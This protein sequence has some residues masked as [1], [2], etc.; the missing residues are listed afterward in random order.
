MK[1]DVI[2]PALNE[3]KTIGNIIKVFKGHPSIGMVLV[4]VDDETTDITAKIANY[5][6][7]N[8]R[9][10]AGLHGKGQLIQ[11]GLESVVG[12]H[13]ILCDGDY[14]RFNSHHVDMVI[15]RA[16]DEQRIIIPNHPTAWE[17]KEH[18]LKIPFDGNAWAWNSGLRSFPVDMAYGAELHGYLVETQLN[19]S[20]KILGI[21][22]AMSYESSLH[23]PLRFTEK[24]LAAMEAD[25][26][27][28]LEHGVFDAADE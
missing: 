3:E 25:R 27:W 2:I 13:V 23:A 24:R 17:W 14:T 9:R 7:A 8:V 18:G 6:G 16:D 4:M 1:T 10:R 19:Q 5:S 22:T 28:G 11:L 26:Q 20:A 21:Y 12:S 15:P